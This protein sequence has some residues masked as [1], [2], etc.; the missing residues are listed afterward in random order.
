MADHQR[1]VL[2]DADAEDAFNLLMELAGNIEAS[3]FMLDEA[4]GALKRNDIEQM[5]FVNLYRMSISWLILSLA[6]IEE[7]WSKYGRLAEETTTKTMRSIVGEIHRKNIVSIRKRTVAHLFDRE[8]SRPIPPEQLQREIIQMMNGGDVMGFI[9]WLRHPD[10][11]NRAGT[12]FATL[13]K[14]GD[15]IRARYSDIRNY[16]EL[17][18]GQDIRTVIFDV[19]KTT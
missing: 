15:E 6:K 2:T 14:F 12:V 4:L 16:N 9:H 10:E 3:I 11:T 13:R 18:P 1:A 19:P 17:A 7:L 5:M 8:T